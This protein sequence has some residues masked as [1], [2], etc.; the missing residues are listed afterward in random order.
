MWTELTTVSV[1]FVWAYSDHC[2]LRAKGIFNEIKTT[3]HLSQKVKPV[4]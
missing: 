4:G 2:S 1:Q 3:V